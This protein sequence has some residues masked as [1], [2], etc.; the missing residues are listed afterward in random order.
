MQPII[1][2]ITCTHNP[3]KDYFDRVLNALRFQ[4]LPY[5]KWEFLLVDNAS[6]HCLKAEFDLKWHPLSKYIREEK[7]GLTQARLCGIEAAKGK[8]LV[9]VDD[10]NVLDQNYL[11]I[12]LEIGQ[13]YKLL[14]A[15]GGQCLPV[16]EVNPPDWTRPYW[17]YLGIRSFDKDDFSTSPQWQ[18][19]PIGAGL[20]VRKMVAKTYAELVKTD[21]IRSS[22]DR[23]GDMLLGC[24]DMDLAYT[25]CDMSLANGVFVDLKLSHLMSPQRLTE[26]YLLKLVEES[27]YST[28]MLNFIRG[29]F[30]KKLSLGMK[31]KQA[32]PI[33]FLPNAWLPASRERKFYK[34]M[35]RG[36]KRGIKEILKC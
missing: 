14:G 36:H 6:D 26:P 11:S 18:T 15:W 29:S 34:A 8:I 24:G 16:F 1:S 21:P 27:V 31:L 12:V 10:D 7:L 33:Y 30:S 35:V 25:A 22:F 19:T 20:C 4:N 5:E 23:R 3:R 9:F 28:V 2:V 17:T 32:I 13:S